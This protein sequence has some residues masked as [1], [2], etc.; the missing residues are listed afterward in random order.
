MKYLQIDLIYFVAGDLSSAVYYN[1]DLDRYELY[2]EDN[3][4]IPVDI[5]PEH[6]A[7]GTFQLL[8]DIFGGSVNG[9]GFKI[10]N[11]KIGLIYGDSITTERQEQILQ[12]LMQK[13]FTADNLVL[14]I[15]SF[16]YEYVTRDTYG[17]AMK[18]T[19]AAIEKDGVTVSVPIFKD[20]KLILDHLVKNLLRV[21]L[22]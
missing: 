14:G 16:T 2:E 21:I 17:M 7:K 15:G 1:A 5:I 12:Q 19:N 10:L 20:L 9:N 13:G 8:W 11:P 18:T 22:R 4:D 3:Y 6:I